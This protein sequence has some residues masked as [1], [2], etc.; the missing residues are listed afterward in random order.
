MPDLKR[1]DY[2]SY[3]D[4]LAHQVEKTADP[5]IRRK[6]QRLWQRDCGNF[7]RWFSVLPEILPSPAKALCLGARLG[8]EVAV[9]REMG[10]HAIGI[11]LVPHPPLVIQGDFHQLPFPYSGLHEG[12]WNAPF[13]LVFSNALDHVY[14]MDRFAA[15]IQRVTRPGCVAIFHVALK[16]LKGFESLWIESLEAVSS[17]F[18]A[19]QAEPGPEIAKGVRQLLLRRGKEDDQTACAT[20]GLDPTDSE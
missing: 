17:R 18:P 20:R 6:F 11:D 15:E 19:W 10:Y 3:D 9:L 14:D 4:Y 7:Q 5:K 16:H 12:N 2:A 13:D 8:A 1:R